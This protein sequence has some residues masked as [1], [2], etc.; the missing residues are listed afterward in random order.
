A[1]SANKIN[2]WQRNVDGGR[3]ANRTVLVAGD[4]R[5][6]FGGWFAQSH[7]RHPIYQYIDN[8]YTDYGLYTRLVNT[9]P[10]AGHD[11]RLT[12][13]LTWSAGTVKA[14]NYVNA[15]GNRGVAL[16]KTD[17]RS[18]NITLYGENSFD[19]VPGVS[20]IAGMQ[21]LHAE[22]KRTDRFN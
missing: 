21:Y 10:L 22:R 12:L 2:D 1:A 4:T 9:T 8:D 18:N 13:G 15:G 17:D 5:Y 14:G 3:I 7:L 19:I 11:N 16:S 20:L 6:E